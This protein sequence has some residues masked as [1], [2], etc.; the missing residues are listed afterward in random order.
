MTRK[1]YLDFD[2]LIDPKEQGYQ[3]QVV[4]SPTG[5]ASTE[6]SLPF[7]VLE[8][9]NFLLR[10]GR[11][12]RGVRRVESS[13][14]EAARAFGTTLFRSIFKDAVGMQF[15]ASLGKALEQ[16][17]GLR[18][19]LRLTST[20]EL[21]DIPWE[22]L[23]DPDLG[24][25]IVLSAETP[26]VRYLALS[27]SAAKLT[28]EPPLR[29]L[30]MIS[31]PN[32]LASLNV[33]EEWC[34]L[35]ES[36]AELE[37]RGGVTLE[38]LE[39]ASLTAL[40]RRL[41]QGTFHIFHFVG[42]GVFDTQ[43]Q[44]GVLLLTNEYGGSSAVSGRD[45]GTMLHD[46]RSLRL[47]VLNS[48]EGGRASRSDPFSGA[49]QS[50]VQQ[51]IPAVIA[52]QFEIT[53]EAAIALAH[54]FYSAL[55]DGYPVDAALAEARK[56]IFARGND[57]EWGTPVLYMRS[58]DGHIFDVA[59]AAEGTLSSS[60]VLIL[61][62]KLPPEPAAT[63]PKLAGKISVAATTEFKPVRTFRTSL[64][65]DWSCFTEGSSAIWVSDG[66]QVELFDFGGPEPAERWFLPDL[67]WKSILPVIW[68]GSL[69]CSDW[70]GNLWLFN[71]NT[72]GRGERLH[73]A[74][75]CDLPIHRLVTGDQGELV[76]ATWDGGILI[77]DAKGQQLLQTPSG[78]V[79]YLP[80]SVLPCPCGRV[81]VVDQGGYLR[82]FD[83]AGNE[84][85]TWRAD[86]KV[87]TVWH[88]GTEDERIGFFLLVDQRQ[89]IQI[90]AGEHGTQSIAFGAP[91]SHV[92]HLMRQSGDGETVVAVV[93]RGLEWLS[94]WPLRIITHPRAP[95]NFDARECIALSD[96]QRRAA[97][98]ALALDATGR[99]LSLEDDN[100]RTHPAPATRS[101]K[102]DSTGRFIYV[103]LE[104]TIEV[105]RNPAFS[106]T[107]P[108]VSLERIEGELAVGRYQQLRFIVRNAG[109]APIGRIQARLDG[110]AGYV[111]SQDQ[112]D[113]CATLLP[114]EVV[115]LSFRVK[116]SECG[117][118]SLVLYLEIEDE[119][120]P[121]TWPK[122]F[123]VAVSAYERG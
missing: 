61:E 80:L 41:R 33:S 3:V 101:M 29:I 21:V 42:H 84:L 112:V 89:V 49:A 25:F 66:K 83:A 14:R 108:S 22:Y 97:R 12:R 30:V 36:L 34:K 121:P 81:A 118:L 16:G 99:L 116:A 78:T 115:V 95:H 19:R 92:S 60:K 65:T 28:V 53:D 46:H 32:D 110:K 11:P 103:A 71:R 44:D 105:Y 38:L 39:N 45:L 85:W 75:Y 13:E 91:V 64:T 6:F 88:D 20:P 102:L 68:Q 55:A 122:Q 120:G 35:K 86:G 69:V 50:L 37:Q 100:L 104:D 58:P 31:S 63:R 76:A 79:P 77:W 7:S 4:K 2:L 72:R 94:W 26:L 1:S 57:V 15:H 107:A 67:R 74:R 82:L 73:H 111:V 43:A 18:L 5:D 54:E 109:A 27:Q 52:M 117:E 113:Q 48:C 93:G 98:I 87:S 24:N 123:D 90:R 40:Q 56:G 114:G 17:S 59:R 96:P 8:I 70:D 23:F 10:I 62:A 9:D 51:G 106:P 47:V 119:A